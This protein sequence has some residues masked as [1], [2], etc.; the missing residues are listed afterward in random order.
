MSYTLYTAA[1]AVSSKPV[2]HR[3]KVDIIMNTFRTISGVAV[4]SIA[5]ILSTASPSAA[6]SHRHRAAAIAFGTGVAAGAV[7]ASTYR[8]N[9]AYQAYAEDQ[10]YGDYAYQPGPGYATTPV[11]RYERGGRSE[12]MC[13][14]S[15]GSLGYTPC[16]NQ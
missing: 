11:Y 4:L 1:L 6:A 14:R 3:R 5:L 9:Y 10:G 2:D 7:A 12:G 16:F 15:P 13:M 8:S